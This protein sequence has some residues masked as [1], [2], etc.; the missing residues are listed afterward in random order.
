M[1][2]TASFNKGLKSV[3][4]RKTWTKVIRGNGK[5]FLTLSAKNLEAKLFLG[6]TLT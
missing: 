6:A 4:I 3:W 5:F 2:D 1:I